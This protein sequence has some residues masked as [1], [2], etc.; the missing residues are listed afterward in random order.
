M[1]PTTRAQACDCGPAAIVAGI[2]RSPTRPANP[3]RVLLLITVRSPI[4]RRRRCRRRG[5]PG[6][7]RCCCRGRTAADD[8]AVD[9]GDD[10]DVLPPPASGPVGWW[11]DLR[12]HVRHERAGRL[13]TRSTASTAA[14]TWSPAVPTRKAPGSTTVSGDQA[15]GWHLDRWNL[16]LSWIPICD[17]LG[18]STLMASVLHDSGA[19]VG[20]NAIHGPVLHERYGAMVGWNM[21]RGSW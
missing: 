8:P 5:R 16:V 7:R 10:S 20:W 18:G 17:A 13:T 21:I 12:R 19:M 2:C 15:F 6:R 3:P 9:E 11:F 14:D 4:A 1:R